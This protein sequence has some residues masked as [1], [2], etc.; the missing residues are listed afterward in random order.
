MIVNQIVSIERTCDDDEH[1]GVLLP[2]MRKFEPI[3]ETLLETSLGESSA[4]TKSQDC[5]LL[6]FHPSTLAVPNTLGMKH[7]SWQSVDLSFKYGGCVLGGKCLQAESSKCWILH[8]WKFRLWANLTV[9][10]GPNV[11]YTFNN[12]MQPTKRIEKYRNICI[13]FRS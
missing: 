13:S 12:T 10:I 1:S 2:H 8:Y 9:G 6:W 11:V 7:I 3:W 4:N 5:P